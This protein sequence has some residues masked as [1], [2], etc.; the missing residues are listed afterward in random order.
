[1]MRPLRI[2]TDIA[3]LPPSARDELLLPAGRD[4]DLRLLPTQAVDVDALLLQDLVSR[5]RQIRAV[6]GL[7]RQL[8]QLRILLRDRSRPLVVGGVHDPD[9]EPGRPD[10]RI[11]LVHP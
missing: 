7:T 9:A 5:S 8:L 3:D 6:R 11:D 1:M 10:E 2:R 4:G